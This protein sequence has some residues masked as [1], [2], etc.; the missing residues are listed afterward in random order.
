MQTNQSRLHIPQQPPVLGSHTPG[1]Y[2][3]ALI[4]PDSKELLW[5]PEYPEI[6]QIS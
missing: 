1:H 6:I 2:F 4:T 3:P 5:T